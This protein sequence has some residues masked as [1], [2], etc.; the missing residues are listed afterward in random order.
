VAAHI[1]TVAFQG[2]D[3]LAI[4]VQ[5]TMANGLP[6]FAV[7]G[8][9]DKAVGE[10]RERVRAALG[11]LGLGL[12]PQRITVNLS[13][14]DVLK[15][16]SHFDLPIALGLL[17]AMEVLS[18]EEIGRYAALGE[19]SLDGAILPVAG[20]LPAAIGAHAEGL[21]L[22]CPAGSGGEAAW[23][24]E[25]EI[26]AAPSLLALINHFKG[27]QVLTPPEP[28]RGRDEPAPPDLA[29]IKGQEA[30]KRALE[31]AAA[32]AHNLLMVGPPGSGKSMLA[33]RLSGILP[34]L[35]AREALEVSMIQSVAGLLAGGAI[36]RRR[37]FR[38]PHHSASLPAL[39]GGGQRARPGEISLAHNGVLFLDELPEFARQ[40]LESLRQPM[41][42]ARAVVARANAHVTYPARFQLVAAMNPCR[43]GYL[44]DPALACPRAP[45]CGRDYQSKISGP[46]FDRI[47]LHVDVPAVSAADLSLP[48][49][50]EGSA[51]VAARVAKAR[52]IQAQRYERLS[53]DR[54]ILT[55]AEADGRLLEEAAAPDADGRSL[56]TQAAER[57]KLSARGYHRVLRVARTLADLDAAPTVRRVHIAEALSYRR[58]VP[59]G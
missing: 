3:T 5:V 13:P 44:D 41:E 26:L 28:A 32:G 59:G 53:P 31:V 18:G 15:E 29:D 40:T 42:S 37:P 43:C 21:G 57:L 46:L 16:G 19:L 34:P 10:S 9:P 38:D 36:T 7:V 45:R 58:V 24:G 51:A 49:P 48:P 52:A 25:V 14:A 50:A 54:R 6:V 55:N 39:V 20:V 47:D 17:V 30:A 35:S 33:Q 12:P 11:A 1:N 22:I 2:I 23:A 4:D 8:L 56:L 27:L